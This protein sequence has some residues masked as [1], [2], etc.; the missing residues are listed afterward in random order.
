MEIASA[1]VEDAAEILAVQRLAYQSEAEIYGDFALPPLL[2]T[3]EDL[4][5]QFAG[6]KS[7]RNLHLYEKL[8]YRVFKR[9]PVHERLTLVFLEKGLP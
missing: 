7:V 1:M 6:H 9:Q 4:R 3:L 5:S 8:G 2:E